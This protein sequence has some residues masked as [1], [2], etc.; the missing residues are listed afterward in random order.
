MKKI[1][2]LATCFA[3]ST[4]L[5]A[6]ETLGP[7]NLGS[8]PEIL[9]PREDC[10]QV[11]NSNAIENGG[12][13]GGAT[14]Q[15]LAVDIDVEADIEFAIET[16]T[17]NLTNDATT[18]DI[19]FYEDAAF[20]PGSEIMTISNATISEQIPVGSN[21]GF[22][23]DQYVIDLSGEG[24]NLIGPAK[25]WMEVV[26]ADGTAWE[27]T[28]AESMGEL[29]AF[30]NDNTGGTWSIGTSEY[31]YTVE[32]Q[33]NAPASVNDELLSQVSI[34]PNPATDIVNI[35]IPSNVQISGVTLH[36]I[37][38]KNTGVSINNGSINI[39]GL[40]KGIYLL[41]VETSAGT[42]TQKVVKK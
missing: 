26:S 21:F 14:N 36:D 10:S 16:V 27:S 23:W 20:L 7:V 28:T 12:F 30:N 35:N 18:V 29:G 9:T 11:V 32:G 24:V 39:S 15:R 4:A 19:I 33:C 41:T 13:L 42:L 40:A 37:L 3:F 8:N 1:T 2:L 34:Y 17:L 5:F 31:V 6:Q 38:G 25:F 22:D